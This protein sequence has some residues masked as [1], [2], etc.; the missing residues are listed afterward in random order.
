[1]AN[2]HLQAT[3]DGLPVPCRSPVAR[4]PEVHRYAMSDCRGVLTECSL[5]VLLG[6]HML[7][8]GCRSRPE[9]QAV[10]Q[11]PNEPDLLS[12]A[13]AHLKEGKT[14]IA[15]QE[16]LSVVRVEPR[17]NEAYYYLNLIHWSRYQESLRKQEAE[18]ETN[19][20]WYPTLPPRK[21]Q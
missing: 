7:I 15:E 14:D 20:L 17:N 10:Q 11:H 16:L 8:G 1:M 21:A 4:V 5:C 9:N 3:R 19:G 2:E 12:A 18:N 6:I 13:K